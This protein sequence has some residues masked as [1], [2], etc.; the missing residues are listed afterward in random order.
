M[1]EEEPSRPLRYHHGSSLFLKSDIQNSEIVI[2]T[3]G[4]FHLKF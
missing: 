3:S 4:S 2:L 1:L